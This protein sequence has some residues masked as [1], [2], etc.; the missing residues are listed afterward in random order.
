LRQLGCRAEAFTL[1][2]LLVVIAIIAILAGMLLPAL[3][4]AKAKAKTI[5]CVNNQKQLG[6]IWML[7]STDNNDKLVSNGQGDTTGPATW[8]PGSF[9]G[10]PTD[11]TNYFLLTDPKRSLFGPYLN[12][13]QLYRCP[14]DTTKVT[15]N[16]KKFD[17]VRSYGMNSYVGWQGDA[18]RSQPDPNYYQFKRASEFNNPGPS[19]TFVFAEIRRESI[20]RPFFGINMA[21]QSFYHVPGDF[22]SPV[23][24]LTFADGHTESHKW[25]D[26]RTLNPGKISNWHDHSIPSAKNRDL[27]WL[28][29]HATA[30]K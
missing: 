2:E 1:I 20:C 14:A 5:Q 22:H 19:S 15:I 28:K 9:E 3:S 29:E 4:R 13:V 21:A 24:V 6:I 11:E 10:T 23:G 16:N 30:K 26:S 8:V 12:T 27:V 25:V 17:P 7:Y 18:Y